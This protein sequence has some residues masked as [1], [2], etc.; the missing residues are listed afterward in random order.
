[1]RSKKN[2]RIFI[3]GVIGMFLLVI[4][5]FF[6]QRRFTRSLEYT[7][8]KQI[9][10]PSPSPVTAVDY[11]KPPVAK[12][13]QN[14]YQIFQTFNNCGPASLSMDLSYFGVYKT[15]EELGQ[16]LRPYQNPQG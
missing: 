11:Q 16:A 8:I 2:Y 12:T 15:Q 14:D 1:M 3:A 6:V 5:G 10:L 13:L 7:K 9:L 4:G